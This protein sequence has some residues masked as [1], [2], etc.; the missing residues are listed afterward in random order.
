MMLVLMM[1]AM[2]GP[3]PQT[4]DAPR[5]NFSGCIRGFETQS[6]TA[7]MDQAAYA[8]AIKGACPAESAALERA[9]V[10]YDVAMGT[11]R[12]VATTNAQSDL[13]DY[14]TTSQE[15]YRDNQPH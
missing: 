7:K 4:L 15:R 11:K 5:R 3:S 2:A 8:V 9:L 13:A 12:A 10:A 6:Q 1:L 14:R